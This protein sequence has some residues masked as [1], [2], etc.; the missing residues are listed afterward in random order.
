MYIDGDAFP[1]PKSYDIVVKSS[2]SV[3]TEFLKINE[4]KLLAIWN[5]RSGLMESEIRLGYGHI[6]KTTTT[7]ISMRFFQKK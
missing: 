3:N 2:K 6:G 1:D 7:S 5:F 4:K